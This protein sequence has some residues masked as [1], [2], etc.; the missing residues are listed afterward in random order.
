MKKL[1]FQVIDFDSFLP[2]CYIEDDILEGG[3]KI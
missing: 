1:S 2:L 3:T